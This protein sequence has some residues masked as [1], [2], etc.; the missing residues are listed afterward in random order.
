M[1]E[2]TTCAPTDLETL[3]KTFT[4]VLDVAE[5]ISISHAVHAHNF[6]NLLLDDHTQIQTF[7]LHFIC[8]QPRASGGTILL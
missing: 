2:L 7:T 5:T 1:E 6:I 3:H 8:T 4:H